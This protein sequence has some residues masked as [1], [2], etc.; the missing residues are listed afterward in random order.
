MLVSLSNMIFLNPTKSTQMCLLEMEKNVSLEILLLLP[1]EVANKIKTNFNI[2]SASDF[3][4]IIRE[5]L[6]QL[7]RLHKYHSNVPILFQTIIPTLF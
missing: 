7:L 6:K 3:D 2:K 5:I 1:T 4:L